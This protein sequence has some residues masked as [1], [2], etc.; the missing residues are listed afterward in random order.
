MALGCAVGLALAL[1]ATVAGAVSSGPVAAP[2]KVGAFSI[3]GSVH[4]LYPG[5]NAPLV[6]TVKD[7]RSFAITVLSIT[8]TVDRSAGGC[9]TSSLLSVT[10]YA[11]A[12]RLQPGQT[13]TVEVTVSMARS[14]TRACQGRS[15]HFDYHGLASAP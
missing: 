3:S 8:T 5:A 15:F 6:L 14:A 12:L 2:V 4:G 10:R 9:P 7:N 1:G 13:A 11:G